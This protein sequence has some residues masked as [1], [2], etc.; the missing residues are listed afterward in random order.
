M[1]KILLTGFEPFLSF[2]LNPTMQIVKELHGETLN[3]YIIEGHILPV[4]F[5]KSE[6][7]LVNLLETV[8]PDIHISLG[9]AGGR[10][11]ITPERIAINVKDGDADNEG[12]K[13]QDEAIDPNGREGY[14]STLPIRAMVDAMNKAGYPASI[15]NTAGTYLCN[16]IMYVGRKY[17]EEHGGTMPSGFIHIPASHELAIEHGRIPSWSHQD[18]VAAIRICLE[19]TVNFGGMKHD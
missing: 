9:L 6:V 13:P 7:E 5:K 3:E 8:N 19:T 2:T 12:N 15:S 10:S 14:F 17:A 11:K 18:L 1:K 4:D 16:N